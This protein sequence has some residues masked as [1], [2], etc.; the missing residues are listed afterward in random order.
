MKAGVLATLVSSHLKDGGKASCGHTEFCQHQRPPSPQLLSNNQQTSKFH[1]DLVKG[2]TS[3]SY[4]TVTLLQFEIHLKSVQNYV[5]NKI[6]LGSYLDTKRRTFSS[7]LCKIR[8]FV[9]IIKLRVNL[10][11]YG[12]MTGG[13]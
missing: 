3:K 8:I 12:A 7:R 11:L 2:E 13:I 10:Q 4:F 5:V 6:Y 1:V 9:T